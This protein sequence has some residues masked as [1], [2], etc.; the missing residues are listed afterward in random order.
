MLAQLR[1][2]DKLGHE[3]Q[4]IYGSPDFSG[5]DAN[6]EEQART[7][8]HILKS[9]A[10]RQKNLDELIQTHSLKA[11][12]ASFVQQNINFYLFSENGRSEWQNYRFAAERS[13]IESLSALYDVAVLDQG[14]QLVWDGTLNEGHGGIVRETF[15]GSCGQSHHCLDLQ[16]DIRYVLD[17]PIDAE[18]VR[19]SRLAHISRHIQSE[20]EQLKIVAGEEDLYFPILL[21]KISWNKRLGNG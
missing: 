4:K 8:F 7:D 21:A 2:A 17:S 3:Q 18:H 6:F 5:Y 1:S 9:A 15:T 16:R 13:I 12:Q 20:V 11:Q 19:F 10:S 14:K